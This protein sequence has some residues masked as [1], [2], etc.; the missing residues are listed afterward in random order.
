MDNAMTL[1]KSRQR[2]DT[3]VILNGKKDSF[4]RSLTLERVS[5]SNALLI[6]CLFRIGAIKYKPGTI[7]TPDVGSPGVKGLVISLLHNG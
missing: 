7:D 3:E 1:L 6:Y 5:L 4:R 2:S